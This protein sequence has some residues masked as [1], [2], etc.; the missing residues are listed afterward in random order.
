MIPIDEL[1]AYLFG[2]AEHVLYKQL[3][4]GL[5]ASRTFRSFAETYRD[6]MRKKIRLA[7]DAAT[8]Q[9]LKIELEVAYLLVQ[10]RRFQVEY[11]KH[12]LGKQRSPDFT[13]T[14]RTRVPFNVEVTR[15]R[16]AKPDQESSSPE[17]PT[18][19]K[20]ME[21]ICDK[22]GQMQPNAINV[23]ML[24]IEGQPEGD[25]LAQAATRLKTMADQKVEAFFTGRG[26][27]NA[28]DFYKQYQNLSAMILAQAP[29]DRVSVPIWQNPIAK[30]PLSKELVGV[31]EKL[32]GKSG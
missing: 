30:Q 19:Y 25:D 23:L 6:K 29:V 1:L 13:V 12:G 15:V 26:F 27:K 28:A 3:E 9:D 10:E 8:L 18:V 21:V 32:G 31:L 2:D 14:F 20:L 22:V 17:R 11:E 24:G 5:R 16:Q 4:T 7:K